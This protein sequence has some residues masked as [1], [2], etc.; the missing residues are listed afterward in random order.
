MYEDLL[1]LPA[2]PSS[3][4]TSGY[5]S[6]QSSEQEST[7]PFANPPNGETLYFDNTPVLA[8]AVDDPFLNMGQYIEQRQS[9]FPNMQQQQQL[10]VFPYPFNM[11]LQAER[12]RQLRAERERQL[13]AERERQLQAERERQLHAERERQLQAERELQLKAERE[14]QLHAEREYQL[15]AERERRRIADERQQQ[16]FE[17]QQQQVDQQRAE[18]MLQQELLDAQRR[19]QLRM[20]EDLAREEERIKALVP[21]AVTSGEETRWSFYQRPPAVLD[22]AANTSSNLIDLSFRHAATTI[23][24]SIS[25]NYSTCGVEDDDDCKR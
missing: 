3:N 2:V 24:N 5:Q 4:Q 20:K 22:L 15:Q 18:L 10:P 9:R 16:M 17:F 13:L 21:R 11:D 7:S 8:P 12:E 1:A 14:R 6:V 25:G 19:E 23:F